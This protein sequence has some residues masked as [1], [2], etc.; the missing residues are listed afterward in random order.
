MLR[1]PNHRLLAL[2]AGMLLACSITTGSEPPSPGGAP[3]AGAAATVGTPQGD[4]QPPPPGR[5]QPLERGQ[6]I[7]HALG[8]LEGDTYTNTREA[9]EQNYALGHRWFEVDLRLTQDGVLV[10]FHDKHEA[11]IGIEGTLDDVSFEEFLGL[12]WKDR[13]SLLSFEALLELLQQ[14]P[15]ALLVTD[16]KL[17][18][19]ATIDALVGAVSAVDS[20][21]FTRIIPQIYEFGDL[22]R[23]EGI[24]RRF[25][26]F[27]S[28]IFT[29]YVTRSSNAEVLHFLERRPVPMVTVPQYP[30]RMERDFLDGLRNT[31][32]Y[33]FTHTLNEPE[34][35]RDY[36]Q[37]G[38]D[39]FYTDHICPDCW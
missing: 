21:L 35:M 25:G 22:D 39:G 26:P 2:S 36:L 12:E 1:S 30:G 23:I 10:C 20:T 28:V 17:W 4:P 9:F 27:Y 24:E 5:A 38:I 7:A 34:T 32:A 6:L 37:L 14:H 11:S 16:T 18:D 3:A 33:L 29:L 13:Y 31:G 15:D 19:E 8:G